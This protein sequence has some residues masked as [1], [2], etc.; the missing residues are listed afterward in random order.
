MRDALL[1]AHKNAVFSHSITFRA[2]DAPLV[3]CSPPP[4]P[5]RDLFTDRRRFA[6][7]MWTTHRRRL[8]GSRTGASAL[9]G[10]R[11]ELTIS[12]EMRRLLGTLELVVEVDPHV[13]FV[14]C[15]EEIHDGLKMLLPQGREILQKLG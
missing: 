11:A 15:C 7:S 8:D 9:S 1:R 10:Q 12:L 3:E 6:R 13:P 2:N 5:A 4:Q 14:D